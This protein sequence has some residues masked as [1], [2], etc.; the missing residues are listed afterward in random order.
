MKKVAE[1]AAVA[2]QHG[3]GVSYKSPHPAEAKKNAAQAA[4]HNDDLNKLERMHLKTLADTNG[5]N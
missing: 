1:I 2:E 4:K 5:G 3:H